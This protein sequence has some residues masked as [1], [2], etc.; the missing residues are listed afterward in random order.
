MLGRQLGMSLV[1]GGLEQG[2]EISSI[3]EVMGLNE[4]LLTNECRRSKPVTK[5]WDTPVFTVWV[6]ETPAMEIN[7]R[8]PSTNFPHHA[9]QSMYITNILPSCCCMNC[10]CSSPEPPIHWHRETHSSSVLKNIISRFTPFPCC[11]FRLYFSTRPFLS[12]YK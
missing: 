5:P 10:P 3:F 6:E 12:G 7:H 4:S 8:R 1:R 9:Y 11:K 2:L